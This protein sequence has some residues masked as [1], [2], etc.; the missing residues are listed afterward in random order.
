MPRVRTLYISYPAVVTALLTVASCY[1]STVAHACNRACVCLSCR[2]F[3]DEI[4][5]L[6]SSLIC[7][8]CLLRYQHGSTLSMYLRYVDH[9]FVF[10]RCCATVDLFKATATTHKGPNIFGLEMSAKYVFC[11]IMA[12]DLYLLDRFQPCALDFATSDC[13]LHFLSVHDFTFCCNFCRLSFRAKVCNCKLFCAD[14]CIYICKLV[15]HFVTNQ[16]L[17]SRFWCRAIV[18]CTFYPCM[19]LYVVAIFV[20]Y[21][22]ERW[23]AITIVLCW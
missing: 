21:Y 5:S 22:F 17:C 3:I 2:T 1:G 16:Q 19:F 10:R 20:A 15:R 8:F 13:Q 11:A 7:G 23:F 9:K 4:F 14:K 12:C 6:N 18:N